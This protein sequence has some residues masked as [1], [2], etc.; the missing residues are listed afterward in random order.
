MALETKPKE[1]GDGDSSTF[2]GCF[3]SADFEPV[4]RAKHRAVTSAQRARLPDILDPRKP[5]GCTLGDCFPKSAFAKLA[6]C[7]RRES[8]GHG[9]SPLMSQPEAKLCEPKPDGSQLPTWMTASDFPVDWEATKK[10]VTFKK[11][12]ERVLIPDDVDES[13]DFSAVPDMVPSDDEAEDEVCGR[14]DDDHCS[15]ASDDEET[16]ESFVETLRKKSHPCADGCGCHQDAGA[17]PVPPC[18]DLNSPKEKC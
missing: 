12:E 7:E 18:E 15:D 2:L 9:K 4:H 10:M 14:C 5:R 11:Q 8:G 16:M 1:Q 6:N 17:V 3:G 13:E